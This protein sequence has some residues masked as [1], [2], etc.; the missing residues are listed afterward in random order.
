MIRGDI[1]SSS[2][3]LLKVPKFR[4]SSRKE[5]F[6]H[7]TGDIMASQT[8]ASKIEKLTALPGV[9]A[10]T[11]KKLVDAKL[12][13]VSKVASA[14]TTKL[15]KIGLKAAVAKKIASAAKSADKATSAA[16]LTAS[17]AKAAA[18]KA[19]AK[20]KATASKAKAAAKKA[21]A[22][23]KATASKAKAAAKEAPAKAKATASKARESVKN[24]AKSTKTKE[25]KITSDDRKKI[26]PSGKTPISKMAWFKN[27]KK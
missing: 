11:A 12:D 21:P 14:G 8:K 27:L 16:K 7:V 25:P 6:L 18:K 22:K 24:L 1:Q 2:I 23:A 19:P 10:A 4:K 3:H 20:A 17:K 13:T 5:A 15:I 9:G 26:G